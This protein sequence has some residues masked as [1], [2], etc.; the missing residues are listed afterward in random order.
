MQHLFSS[1]VSVSR[2]SVT[3]G[4]GVPL[5]SF[6]VVNP[7]LRCRLD[8]NFLRPGKDQPAAPEA[9]RAP[10][11]V[12]VMFCAVD[13]DLRAGDRVKAVAGPVDG[14]F[15]IRVVPDVATDYSSGH[16]KEVQIVEVAQAFSEEGGEYTFGN[17]G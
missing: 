12:G 16:H 7:S 17:E 1:T 15:E 14:V 9:G 6:D 5:Y 2:L 8:L 10:D 13:A 11:R 3:D 4:G